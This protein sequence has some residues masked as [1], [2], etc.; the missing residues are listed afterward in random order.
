[1][2]QQAKSEILSIDFVWQSRCDW[3]KDNL[4]SGYHDNLHF[5]RDRSM[6]DRVH[7]PGLDAHSEIGHATVLGQ[8]LADRILKVEGVFDLVFTAQEVTVTISFPKTDQ[9]FA[10]LAKAEKKLKKIFDTFNKEL[11]DVV[12][13]TET[14]QITIGKEK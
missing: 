13:T 1:M 5:S 7:I 3:V 8:K 14:E 6:H 10:L 11:V 2:L 4:I 9:P 12:N